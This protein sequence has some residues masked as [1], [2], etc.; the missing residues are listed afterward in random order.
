MEMLIYLV[1]AVSFFSTNLIQIIQFTMFM[2]GMIRMNGLKCQRILMM[3]Q[4]EVYISI[5]LHFAM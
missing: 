5:C 4:W 1:L 3:V 2:R